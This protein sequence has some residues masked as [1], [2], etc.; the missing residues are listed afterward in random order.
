MHLLDEFGGNADA[1]IRGFQIAALGGSAT[2]GV[3]IG[4]G[5]TAA[6]LAELVKTSVDVYYDHL[7]DRGKVALKDLAV[8]AFSSAQ[9]N[10]R[11]L[12]DALDS[13]DLEVI[14]ETAKEQTWLADDV[15][16]ELF[17][18]ADFGLR[19]YVDYALA[20]IAEVEQRRQLDQEENRQ[21]FN[22][23]KEERRKI[24]NS[25]EVFQSHVGKKF[26]KIQ[27]QQLILQSGL[28]EVAQ[29]AKKNSS[30]LNFLKVVSLKN[31]TDK[32][33]IQAIKL[34]WIYEKNSEKQAQAVEILEKRV[35][36]REQVDEI[37]GY[38]A[39]GSGLAEIA[40][41][42]GILQPED[43]ENLMKNIRG[44][45]TVVNAAGAFLTGN[46]IGGA[47]TL[48]GGFGGGSNA[49]AARHAEIMAAFGRVFDNQKKILD[50]Q[51][52]ILTGLVEID[53]TIRE[54][55][56][57]TMTKLNLIVA[58]GDISIEHLNYLSTA[59]LSKCGNFISSME[60][61]RDT[62]DS[63]S[64]VNIEYSKRV[65]HFKTRHVDYT[66]CRQ[67]LERNL[68]QFGDKPG[69]V[70]PIMMFMGQ[71]GSNSLEYVEK[72]IK[73]ILEFT[74][75]H[76]EEVP[77]YIAAASLIGLSKPSLDNL[78][79]RIDE[80]QS[81]ILTDIG[82]I[83]RN[84]PD[85]TTNILAHGFMTA[86]TKTWLSPTI[87]SKIYDYTSNLYYY[88]DLLN[89]D[90]SLKSKESLQ[91]TTEYA[92]EGEMLLGSLFNWIEAVLIQTTLA[93]G[94]ALLPTLYHYVLGKSVENSN[95]ETNRKNLAVEAVRANP[96][97]AANVMRYHIYTW[98]RS[99]YGE[100]VGS[101]PSRAWNTALSYA[102]AVSRFKAGS[103]HILRRLF[104]N[105]IELRL[106][107]ESDFV[108]GRF[109]S[110][111]WTKLPSAN[112][113]VEELFVSH[114]LL[115]ELASMRI[116]ISNELLSYE[117]PK[118]FESDTML[119][120]AIAFGLVQTKLKSYVNR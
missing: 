2:G 111:N 6:V 110:L 3:T 35:A 15:A 69:G 87:V 80:A 49:A 104:D 31:M 17:D 109:G 67:S 14:K 100:Q 23:A 4:A 106:D 5:V 51:R 117:I 10:P 92:R 97:I 62:T 27:N 112:E 54:I 77:K 40:T 47:L 44:A 63:E 19:T 95:V 113:L 52:K 64:I 98:L 53:K 82:A 115:D 50:N 71:D 74:A 7:V 79:Y 36:V 38:L 58:Q 99:E 37:T 66:P 22:A 73:P 108:E 13:G 85:V 1:T 60:V 32:E 89:T 118:E 25:I 90:Q 103:P 88:Y 65:N 28:K 120:D 107:A 114:P 9:F 45:E 30:D 68:L 61:I 81:V 56:K 84:I 24:K 78:K 93:Q 72:R 34:G 48:I 96:T 94:D 39:T 18:A 41:A 26:E 86:E 8:S 55:H 29:R 119:R 75:T 11:V 33:K 57:V 16:N 76:V 101:V 83:E 102:Y 12:Q 59:D 21:L 46:Y 105:T 20:N 42:L 116:N 91:E 70:S 43:A